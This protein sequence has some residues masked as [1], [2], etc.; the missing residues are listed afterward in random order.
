MRQPSAR[1]RS[2]RSRAHW[3]VVDWP[4]APA[5][6]VTRHVW[7]ARMKPRLSLKARALQLLA[8]REHSRVELR[9]KLVSYL[10]QQAPLATQGGATAQASPHSAEDRPFSRRTA[11]TEDA[12]AEVD[13]L[14]DWLTANQH[15]SDARFVE[16][17]VR[18]RAA[19][20]GN[21][22]IR[23][24]LAQHGLQLTADEQQ[25]LKDTEFARARQVWARKFHAPVSD[26]TGHARQVRFLAA[27]GFSSDVIR[28]LLRGDDD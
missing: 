21:L 20:Q 2:P 15:L 23:Q 28:R 17:R 13:A 24:E 1:A 11:P 14:L 22:R 12:L 18:V 7:A 19:R 9:R 25:A 5:R 16:T 4:A 8:Q 27:R 3:R 6:P 10:T 26:A